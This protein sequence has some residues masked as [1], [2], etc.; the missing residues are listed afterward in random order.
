MKRWIWGLMVFAFLIVGH[1]TWAQIAV[2]GNIYEQDSITPIE[3][4]SVTFSGITESGD[5]LVYLFFT[6]TLGY[7]SDSLEAGA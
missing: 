6:D 4:A 1:K 2:S 3:A 7:F 5:T